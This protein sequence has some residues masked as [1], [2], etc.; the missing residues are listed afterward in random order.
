MGSLCYLRKP[1]DEE[2]LTRCVREALKSGWL[3]GR[4]FVSSRSAS[5]QGELKYGAARFVRFR[6]Q[7]APMGVDDGPADRQPHARSAGLR[8]VEGVEDPLEMRRIDAR[9]GIAHSHEDACLVLLGADHQLSCPL[10]NRAH[11]FSRIQNQIQQDLLQLNAIPMNRKQS[12]CKPGLDRNAIP[13][14]SR[15]APM[16][17]LRRLPR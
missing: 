17:S 16:R 1:V 8:G 10:L 11:C 13:D 4:G 14:G 2:H 12:L 6:P 15:F 5:G 7:L 9:P 3:A